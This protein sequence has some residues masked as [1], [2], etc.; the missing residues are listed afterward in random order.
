MVTL[1]ADEI[2]GAI[3][4]EELLD[5]APSGFSATGHIGTRFITKLGPRDLPKSCFVI[6]SAHLNL[7][8]EYLPYKHIIGQ[9]I[10]DVCA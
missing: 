9:V 3:L 10:L 2:L 4:P 6:V 7:N 8:D 5:G 1:G